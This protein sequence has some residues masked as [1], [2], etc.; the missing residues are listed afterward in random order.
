MSAL[1]VCELNSTIPARRSS[2]VR[3]GEG[4]VSVMPVLRKARRAAKA[5]EL[6]LLFSKIIQQFSFMTFEEKSSLINC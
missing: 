4:L 2:G 5:L 1:L 3:D 6:A